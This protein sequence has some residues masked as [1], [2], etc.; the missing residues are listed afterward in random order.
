VI[1]FGDGE[2]PGILGI[3]DFGSMQVWK[4]DQSGVPRCRW[5][6]SRRIRTPRQ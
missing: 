6:S 1:L 3:T 2:S 5:L 4:F